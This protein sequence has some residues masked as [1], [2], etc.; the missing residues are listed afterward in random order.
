MGFRFMNR[1]WRPIVQS[2]VR[3]LP[4]IEP[5]PGPD[6][7]TGFGHGTI[8]FDVHLFIFQAAPQPLDEDVV[9]K[10]PFAVHA[11]PHTLARKLVQERG[12]GKLHALIGVEY[13]RTAMPV[14]RL[15]Q[16]VD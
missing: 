15:A 2:L 14:H 7:L 1:A 16:R 10:S 5:K 4:I 3:S 11:D 12:T 13:F 9:E 6:T 8:R